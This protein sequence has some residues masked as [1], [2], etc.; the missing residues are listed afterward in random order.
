MLLPLYA[1]FGVRL[2]AGGVDIRY[3][4]IAAAQTARGIVVDITNWS[5]KPRYYGEIEV[6]EDDL[7]G[8]V[9]EAAELIGG[10]IHNV[11]RHSPKPG[12]TVISVHFSPLDVSV[13]ELRDI[14]TLRLS[15][16]GIDLGPTFLGATSLLARVEV[17]NGAIKE[18]YV[19]LILLPADLR[20]DRSGNVVPKDQRIEDR[21][22]PIVQTPAQQKLIDMDHRM[23]DLARRIEDRIAARQKEEAEKRLAEERAAREELQR[24]LDDERTTREELQR[25]MGELI[26]QLQAMQAKPRKKVKPKAK[27]KTKPKAKTMAKSKTKVKRSVPKAIAKRKP[28]R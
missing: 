5:T 17:Q 21:R 13:E 7:Y 27:A 23:T 9:L 2:D 28:K 16:V 26:R 20:L 1:S 10:S 3:P 6:H 18:F 4:D 12:L 24:R 11:E 15:A 8:R 19:D 22:K 14:L 25:Q